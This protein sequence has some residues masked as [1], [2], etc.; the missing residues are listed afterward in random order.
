MASSKK[1]KVSYVSLSPDFSTVQFGRLDRYDSATF[2][3]HY[4]AC[5]MYFVEAPVHT[6]VFACA[7]GATEF[8]YSIHRIVMTAMGSDSNSATLN[9]GRIKLLKKLTLARLLADAMGYHRC[10]MLIEVKKG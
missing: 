3:G 9:V 6:L 4:Y 5:D 2:L 10:G 7:D 1:K 8:P